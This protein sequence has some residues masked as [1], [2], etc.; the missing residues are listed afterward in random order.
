MEGWK[1]VTLSIR[2]DSEQIDRLSILLFAEQGFGRLA[3]FD[4]KKDKLWRVI[5]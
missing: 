4:F 2:T 1:M 5:R 3:V